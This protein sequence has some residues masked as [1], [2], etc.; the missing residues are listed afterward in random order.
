MTA[1]GKELRSEMTAMGKELRSEMQE[2]R[3]E[4]RADIHVLGADLR[5]EMLSGFNRQI[6]WL[7]TFGMAWSSLL[8]AIT[9]FAG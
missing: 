3:I 2:M 6:K 7:V 8:V 1:T 5:S 9:R 4:L